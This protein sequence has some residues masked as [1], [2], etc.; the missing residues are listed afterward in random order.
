MKHLVV[1]AA[2]DYDDLITFSVIHRQKEL[3][4]GRLRWKWFD[5]NNGERVDIIVN[6]YQRPISGERFDNHPIEGYYEAIVKANEW[7]GNKREQIEDEFIKKAIYRAIPD[8]KV[9]GRIIN[10]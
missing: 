9:I 8:G 6:C 1:V 5:K 4:Y 10:I 2:T 7:L 3:L